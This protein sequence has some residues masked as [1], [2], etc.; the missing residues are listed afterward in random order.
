MQR[1]PHKNKK[2]QKGEPI[3]KGIAADTRGAEMAQRVAL[4]L[5]SGRWAKAIHKALLREGIMPHGFS[6]GRSKFCGLVAS[7]FC[8]TV[9][10]LFFLCP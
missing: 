8:P 6:S 7:S 4:E 3:S 5:N 9:P 2:T 10:C 1:E